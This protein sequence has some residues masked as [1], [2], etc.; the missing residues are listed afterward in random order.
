VDEVADLLRQLFSIFRH[1]FGH[2]FTDT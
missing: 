1:R 2:K